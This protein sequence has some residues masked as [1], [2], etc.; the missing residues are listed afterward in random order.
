MKRFLLIAAIVTAASSPVWAS[1]NDN[2]GNLLNPDV[3][4]DFLNDNAPTVAP[5]NAHA[6]SRVRVSKSMHSQPVSQGSERYGD[7]RSN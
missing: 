4:R 2:P 3:K 6:E 1:Q 5:M 7:S